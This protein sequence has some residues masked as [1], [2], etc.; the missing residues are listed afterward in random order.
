VRYL[1]RTNGLTG[2]DEHEAAVCDSFWEHL[3]DLR[4]AVRNVGLNQ[5][6]VKREESKK[7]I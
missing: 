7:K 3:V 4:T 1:A 2:K 5:D 6:A